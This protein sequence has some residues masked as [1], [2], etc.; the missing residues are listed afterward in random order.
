MQS[1]QKSACTHLLKKSC[2]TDNLMKS[3]GCLSL[4]N[5]F[6]SKSCYDALVIAKV[7]PIGI[8]GN[9]LINE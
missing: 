9:V 3:F 8:A 2:I 4:E 5:W 6:S 7:F 1:Y